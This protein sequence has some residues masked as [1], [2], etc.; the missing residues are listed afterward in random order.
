[1]NINVSSMASRLR[2]FS[3]LSPPESLGSK[4]EEDPQRFV[5]EIF[6]ILSAMGVCS[7][8]KEGLSTYHVKYV[9]RLWYEQ[10]KDERLRGAG[11][12]SLEVFKEAFIDSFFPLELRE[13]KF[14][15][16]MNLYEGLL[17]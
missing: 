14:V 5:N 3:R 11:P 7:E 4:V 12:I 16:L 2:D 15:E 9:A 13:Q 8:E 6:K 10:W 1:M 17:V